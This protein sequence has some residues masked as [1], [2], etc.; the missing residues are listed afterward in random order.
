MV[1]D[2]I[3]ELRQ[4]F[5]AVRQRRPLFALADEMHVNRMTL[6]NFA[7]GGRVSVIVLERIET[8]VMAQTAQGLHDDDTC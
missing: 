2:A 4:Q 5:H 3:N 1:K 6:S 8:W 7:G